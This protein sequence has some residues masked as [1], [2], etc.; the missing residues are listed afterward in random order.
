MID[1]FDKFSLV[2]SAAVARVT[3]VAKLVVKVLSAAVALI[4]SCNKLLVKV[5]SIAVALVTSAD[6]LVVKELSPAILAAISAFKLVVKFESLASTYD[7][8]ALTEGYFVFE[9]A[10]VFTFK[11]LFT[12]SSF[13]KS[14]LVLLA[15]SVNKL[16]V[17]TTSAAALILA[18]F[19]KP[20]PPELTPE[21]T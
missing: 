15:I 6:K 14:A 9:A 5:L 21:S 8:I 10:S 16:F 1:L 19:V 12:K 11:D 2:A 13:N 18:S 7:L 3:S 4:N 17:K 20:V